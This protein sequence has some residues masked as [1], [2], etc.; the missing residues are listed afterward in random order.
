MLK[1]FVL[2]FTI[3]FVYSA[4]AAETPCASG[5]FSDAL[6]ANSGAISESDSESTVQK[7]VRQTFATKDTL[8]RVLAC[9]EIANTAPT[10]PIIFSP[11]TYTFPGGRNITVNYE[12]SPKLLQQRMVMTTKRDTPA[13]PK[14]GESND[15]TVWTNTD[16]AWYGI[17]VVEH[18]SLSEFVGPDKNNTVS[19]E[20]IRDNIDTLYPRGGTCTNRT[21]L[22]NDNYAI[23]RAVAQTVNLDDDTNDYYVAGDR[24]LEWIG[25]T[26]IALDVI[27]TVATMG[28]YTAVLG[29]TKAARA[30]R[31]LRGLG[32]TIKTLSK[33]DDVV[34][35]VRATQDAARLTKEINALDKVADAAKIKDKTAELT[36]I[37]NSI[38]TLESTDDAKKYR[39]ATKTFSEL[40]KYRHSLRGM[41]IAHRGNVIAR[42]ARAT[43]SAMTGNSLI[44]HAHKLGRSSGFSNRVRDW[45]FDSTLRNSGMVAKVGAGAGLLTGILKTA[46]DMY[47]ITDNTTDEFTSGLDFAPLLLLSA[48]DLATQEDVVNY[49]MWLMWMGDSTNP[50]DD[51]A[52][53]LQVMDFAAKF[54]QDLIEI[55]NGRNTPCNVDIFVVRP[56]LQNPGTDNSALYYLIMNDTPW[57]T[58]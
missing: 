37:N 50:A 47:D 18:G 2:A 27:L 13:N 23:N 54:H 55:Q 12:T 42:T 38:R 4:N 44:K 35:Y 11:I 58:N 53:Y 15:G 32:S 46:G 22:A 36:R 9:P 21:A 43:K 57:T 17:M 25:Y 56:V 29:A 7:W 49:G 30:S 52:A 3:L 39:D 20:Y 48:D 5:V 28:G 26:E 8:E 24:N 10:Q 33:T 45:L 40:N 34:K 14:I 1:T 6:A 19:L 16:P 51:D 31:A 41:R